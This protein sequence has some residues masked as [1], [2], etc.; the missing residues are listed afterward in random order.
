MRRN[1][2]DCLLMG[3]QA[4]VLYG[5][6]EFSRDIDFV[7]HVDSGN[8]ARLSGA[9]DELQ[10]RV[11]AVPPFAKDYLDRGH[12][13]H[14]RC[15]APGTERLRIDV[16][17]RLRGVD[18]FEMLWERRTTLAVDELEI[19]ALSLPDLIAAKRTQRDK[20]WLMTN[21]LVEA[22]HVRHRDEATTERIWFW[23][24]QSFDLEFIERRVSEYPGVGDER[25]VIRELRKGNRRQAAV[26]LE[27]ERMAIVEADREYWKPLKKELEALRRG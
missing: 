10:A 14:F 2:V 7:L 23:L 24:T 1:G 15:E 27:S 8:L 13:V 26:V 5:G 3:G 18:P 22:H 6:A 19:D 9:V 17:S 20:D 21:R 25:E 12:A 11:I 16:M 4:C